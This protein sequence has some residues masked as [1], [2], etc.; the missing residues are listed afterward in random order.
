MNMKHALMASFALSMTVATVPEAEAQR[1]RKA[2]AELAAM[3]GEMLAQACFACHG[4]GG[5]SIADG[6]P[7]IGGQNAAYLTASLLRFKIPDRPAT[8]MT[9]LAKGYTDAEL[10]AMSIYLSRLPFVRHPQVTDP[11]LVARGEKVYKA[12]CEECHGSG[13][14]VSEMADYPIIAGQRL[15][16]LQ[17]QMDEIHLTGARGVEAKFS[18]QLA[19]LPHADVEAALHFFAAQR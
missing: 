13:G 12:V 19:K 1:G 11:A 7:T 5:G 10:E 18:A 9:R 2:A 16:Y 17:M 8:V 15:Q 4:P 6:V 14:R 3:R